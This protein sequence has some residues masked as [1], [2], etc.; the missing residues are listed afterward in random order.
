MVQRN[1]ILAD[2]RN[3]PFPTLTDTL[4]YRFGTAYRTADRL[5]LGADVLGTQYQ[6]VLEPNGLFFTDHLS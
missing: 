2:D 3:R 5:A 4:F 1:R 6:A